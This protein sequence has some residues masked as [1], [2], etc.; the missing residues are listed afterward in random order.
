M[1]YMFLLYWDD[2]NPAD[3]TEM[4]GIMAAHF[5][6][7]DK[8]RSRNAYIHSEAVGGRANATTIRIRDGKTLLTDGPYAETKEVMGGYYVLDCADL[9]EAL[10][11][12]AQIPDAK[13]GAVEVRPVML[14]PGWDYG[15]TKD[16]A[17]QGM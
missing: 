1:L 17:R 7:A 12:A 8:A 15:P 13:Y 5:A 11:Y 16:R 4:A 14:V 3:E 2:A 9:D 6:V 10:E